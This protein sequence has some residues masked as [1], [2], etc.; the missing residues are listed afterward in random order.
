[1]TAI[2]TIPAIQFGVTIIIINTCCT[3]FRRFELFN[4]NSL[5][6]ESKYYVF[7]NCSR[8]LCNDKQTATTMFE[9]F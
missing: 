9:L 8:V 7:I 5:E 1:M 3:Y 6:Y 2:Q 4:E